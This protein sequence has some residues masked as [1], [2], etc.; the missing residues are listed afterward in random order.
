L[1]LDL[2]EEAGRAVVAVANGAML[3][4]AAAVRVGEGASIKYRVP[5]LMCRGGE[6]N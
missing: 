3:E 1:L 2:D 4:G 6:G 5:E